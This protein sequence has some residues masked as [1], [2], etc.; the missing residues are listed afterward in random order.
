[1]CNRGIGRAVEIRT[2]HGAVHRGIIERVSPDRVFLRPLG[3]PPCGYG[4]FG[5]RGYGYGGYGSPWGW[6]FGFAAGIAFG[7]IATLAFIPF[8]FW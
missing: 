2:I 3:G 1:M 7:V 8:F 5:Y 6:G 4:G